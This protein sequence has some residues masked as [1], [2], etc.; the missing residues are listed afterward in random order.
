[1]T[2]IQFKRRKKKYF[3]KI[4][5]IG[6]FLFSIILTVTVVVTELLSSQ[7]FAIVTYLELEIS[8]SIMELSS[9]KHI[10]II[11]KLKKTGLR[12]HFLLLLSRNSIFDHFFYFFSV[13]LNKFLKIVFFLNLSRIYNTTT[14]IRPNSNRI[15]QADFV[16]FRG[17][18]SL[19]NFEKI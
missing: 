5:T 7:T 14:I 13:K 19:Q 11:I 15:F 2:L 8:S 18:I 3:Y 6:Y 9:K 10:K 17:S 1:M 4:S 16:K 12:D